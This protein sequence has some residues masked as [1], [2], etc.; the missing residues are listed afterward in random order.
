LLSFYQ[1][2][3]LECGVDEAGRGCLAGP[4]VAAAVILPTDFWHADIQ[5]SKKISESKRYILREVIIENAWAWNIGVASVEMIDEVNI[6][7]ATYSAMNEAIKGLNVRPELL[8]V[9][10]NRFQNESSIPHICLVQGDS[11]NLNVAA[12]SILA[13]TFRDDIMQWLHK[14]FPDY[15]WNR[16][17]GYPTTFHRLM[18]QKLGLTPYHRKTFQCFPSFDLFSEL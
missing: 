3:K 8:V 11:K 9:D 5:D 14:E 16:N 17:K 12:A 1:K 15:Q 13:K 6:L 10:G 7:N 18:I 2:E 4:V